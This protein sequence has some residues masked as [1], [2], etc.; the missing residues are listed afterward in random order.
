MSFFPVNQ[1]RLTNVAIVRYKHKGKRFELACY[2]NKVL[3]YRSGVYVARAIVCWFLNVTF[4][5]DVKFFVCLTLCEH[6]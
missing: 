6:H 3:D 4:L 2:Q 1:K 5:A